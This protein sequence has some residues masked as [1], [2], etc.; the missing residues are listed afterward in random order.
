MLP[1]MSTSMSFQ[2]KKLYHQIHQLKLATDIGATIPFLYLLWD[3]KLLL[4]FVVGFAPPIV[5]SAAMMKWTP[6]L[7]RIKRS[8]FGRYIRRYMTSAI[9]AI[10]FLSLVPMA[11]GAWLHQPGYIAFG[12]AIL[13]AAWCN[14]LIWKRTH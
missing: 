2:E 9:E 12:L 11:Y 3:H 7:E 6:D 13:I 4:A 8:W 1:V 5:V 10:R 14:G